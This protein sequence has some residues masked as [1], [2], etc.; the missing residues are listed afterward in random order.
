M[1]KCLQRRNKIKLFTN[2]NGDVYPKK[3]ISRM[4]KL[5]D[6]PTRKLSKKQKEELLFDSEIRSVCFNYLKLKPI[7]NNTKNLYWLLYTLESLRELLKN[8]ESRIVLFSPDVDG[9]ALSDI[10]SLEN[11]LRPG[12]VDG[13]EIM[14][15]L[16]DAINETRYYKFKKFIKY[17]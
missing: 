5:S 3:E 2:E 1:F 17:G 12:C 9:K 8:T 6:I 7:A 16:L 15:T 14:L 10:I 13:Y 4:R 11:E